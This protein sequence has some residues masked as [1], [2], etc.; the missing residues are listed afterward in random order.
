MTVFCL[1][2]ASDP[3]RTLSE[4]ERGKLSN[5]VAQA[6][7]RLATLKDKKKINEKDY[8]TILQQLTQDQKT[9]ESQEKS[10]NV[11]QEK[12]IQ[13]NVDA[14]SRRYSKRKRIAL[15]V[16]SAWKGTKNKLGL[17]KPIP[18]EAKA[19]GATVG[20]ASVAAAAHTKENSQT[21]A[22]TADPKLQ[23]ASESTKSI[24]TTDATADQGMMAA[25]GA[26]IDSWM[27]STPTETPAPKQ[28]TTT[29]P[30][31]KAEDPPQQPP[32]STSDKLGTADAPEA[33]ETPKK[34]SDLDAAVVEEDKESQ[35]EDTPSAKPEDSKTEPSFTKRWFGWG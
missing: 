26:Y 10:I 4:K 34:V 15:G 25:F 21:Q 7:A 24:D 33:Q 18:Q 17:R 19:A 30:E 11:A 32:S 35:E 29:K 1:Q 20:T 16:R 22:S 6:L 8:L 27:P 3:G 9:L 2:A 23:D 14:V 28:E 13:K 5:K 12:A 31:K